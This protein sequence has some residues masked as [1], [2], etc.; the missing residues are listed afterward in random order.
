MDASTI[1][2]ITVILVFIMLTAMT[3]WVALY[4]RGDDR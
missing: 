3:V 2:T 4:Y 1:A